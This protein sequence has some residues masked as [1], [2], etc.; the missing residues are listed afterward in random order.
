[1]TDTVVHNG[2]LHASEFKDYIDIEMPPRIPEEDIIAARGKCSG[3]RHSGFT[4][5]SRGNSAKR[6]E[7]LALCA[8][9]PVQAACRTVADYLDA[10]FGEFDLLTGIWAGEGPAARERRRQAAAEAA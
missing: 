3:K 5:L 10:H 1:M 4:D 2:L 6:R 7:A 9:C 8:R